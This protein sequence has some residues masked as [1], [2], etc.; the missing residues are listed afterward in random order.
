MATNGHVLSLIEMDAPEGAA[1]MPGVILP[2]HVV[3]TARALWD[4]GADLTLT[5]SARRIMI[6]GPGAS[7][8]SKVIDGTYP[9]YERV[10][11]TGHAATLRTT[12]AALTGALERVTT[13]ATERAR[14]V[15]LALEAGE[16]ALSAR[17]DATGNA[18]ETLEA[19]PENLA[20]G[21]AIG[22]NARYALDALKSLAGDMVEICMASPGDPMIWRNPAAAGALWVVMP[23]RVS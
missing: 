14:S 22:F 15:K 7:L 12:P 10:V 8:V 11:P 23:L 6:A 4:K 9:D 16:I 18:V 3:R 5:V 20:E 2:R 17:G 1:G 13:V 21:Y 19:E